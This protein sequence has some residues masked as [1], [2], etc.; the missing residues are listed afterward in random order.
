MIGVN[1]PPL[2]P[3][4]DLAAQAG[5]QSAGTDLPLMPGLIG[6]L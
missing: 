3:L 5:V 1:S 2:L 6:C 4:E